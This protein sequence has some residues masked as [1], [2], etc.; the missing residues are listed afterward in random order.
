[1]T[2]K[3]SKAE[4]TAVW[5]AC[6]HLD[7]AA[8]QAGA[9]GRE[10]AAELVGELGGFLSTIELLFGYAE[11]SNLRRNVVTHPAHTWGDVTVSE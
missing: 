5:S 11:A 7:H 8:I 2:R 3:M 9:G 4:R 6:T 1:M 10:F